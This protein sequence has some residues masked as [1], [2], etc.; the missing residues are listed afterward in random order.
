MRAIMLIMTLKQLQMEIATKKH[1]N[2]YVPR[3]T[4]T[5]KYS[6]NDIKKC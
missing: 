6:V 3:E 1:R 2:M 4:I 5:R